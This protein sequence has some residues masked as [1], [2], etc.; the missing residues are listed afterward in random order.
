MLQGAWNGKKK[1]KLL[2]HH[3]YRR[4]TTERPRSL[5]RSYIFLRC[6]C[7]QVDE[8]IIPEFRLRSQDLLPW[9]ADPGCEPWFVPELFFGTLLLLRGPLFLRAIC[10]NTFV[11][12]R[13][14]H[15]T[16]SVPVSAPPV[17][18]AFGAYQKQNL[19]KKSATNPPVQNKIN[20]GSCGEGKRDWALTLLRANPCSPL[21][22]ISAT[23]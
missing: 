1:Q 11:L 15:G 4:S 18:R 2:C 3:H 13:F 16:T 17:N 23:K 22:E 9:R 8:S 14:N 5:P 19:A 21:Y 6:S 10:L 12:A 20:K 7:H